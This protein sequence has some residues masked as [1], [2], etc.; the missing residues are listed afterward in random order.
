MLL[1]QLGISVSLEMNSLGCPECRPVFR[2]R[3]LAFIEERL[4]HLCDDCKRRRVTNP[5]RVLDCKNPG[6]RAQV[7]DAPSM[8]ENLCAACDE[9]FKVVRDGLERLGVAYSLN[10]FMVRGL[11]YYCRTTFE[12]ITGDLGA[13]AA[14]GGGGRYDGLV[15][16]LGGPKNTPGIG[17]AMGIERLVL[18]L[19]QQN[20][21]QEN[22]VEELDIFLAGLGAPASEVCFDLVHELR[23]QGLRAGMDHEGKS[24]KSQMKQA[25]KAG[26]A[27]VLIVG[28]DE[29]AAGS[30]VLR[31]MATQEQLN[32]ALNSTALGSCLAGR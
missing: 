10:K 23:K 30:G 12:F 32:I 18:L 3:L 1:G 6:C 29:L 17:F 24:L 26:S 14:V 28:D 2:K 13:Q 25:D 9:H 11:D 5:L 20:G 8:L 7:A 21:G 27:Y 4:E 31:N 19:Q 15:E 16:Q 22:R